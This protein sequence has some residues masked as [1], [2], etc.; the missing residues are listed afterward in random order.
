[1]AKL[2]PYQIYALTRWAGLNEQ[3]G[4]IATA[5]A[6]CESGGNTDAHNA[7]PP[8]DSYGLWQIN[9]L[10]AMGPARRAMFGLTSN[11]Q[12]L[13]PFKNA[14]AMARISGNGLNFG[15]WSCYTRGGYKDHLAD[16]YAA[17]A[18]G[19]NWQTVVDA[20]RK[21]VP[22]PSITRQPSGQTGPLAPFSAAIDKLSWIFQ[23]HNWWRIGAVI[24]GGILIVVAL[25]A[26]LGPT[27]EPVTRAATRVATKGMVG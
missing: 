10:G 26:L 17:T 19:G 9:M 12:L 6:L 16:A 21:G 13:D 8:D 25:N 5:I 7:V 23:A 2:Q 11:A 24:A 20:I 15:P 22:A 27:I 1:M 3:R 18:Q 4:A 14:E